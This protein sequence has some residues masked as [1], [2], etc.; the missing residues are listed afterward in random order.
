MFV[1][2][3]VTF[4]LWALYYAFIVPEVVSQ[5][6]EPDRNKFEINCLSIM[7]GSVLGLIPQ[8]IIMLI[9]FRNFK[10][11]PLVVLRDTDILN[12]SELLYEDTE[13]SEE[14]NPDPQVNSSDRHKSYQQNIV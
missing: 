1:T 14:Q 12:R 6:T 3:D 5:E 7:I 9:H 4:L 10:A 11:V 2:F 8:C 13:D